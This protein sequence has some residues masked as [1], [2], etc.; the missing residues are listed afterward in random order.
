MDWGNYFISRSEINLSL[1]STNS[2]GLIVLSFVIS[3]T[4]STFCFY[5]V[6]VA[7]NTADPNARK[8]A[9]VS[10]ALTL[11]CSVWSMHF[12]GLLALRICAPVTYNMAITLISV[13][14]SMLAS[15]L[16][17]NLFIHPR[18]GQLRLM[19]SGALVGAGIG[20]MHY[21]GMQAMVM[22]PYIRYQPSWFSLSIVVAI[23][24]STF[25][26]WLANSDFTRELKAWKRII[27][28]GTVLGCAVCFMH[29]LGMEAAVFVGKPIT[30]APVAPDG[31]TALATAIT[32]GML[33]ICVNGVGL[34]LIKYREIA[35]AA[36]KES[37]EQ[38]SLIKQLKETQQQLL[39]S[40]KM[41]SIGQLAAGIAHEIN[42][43]IGFVYS[44]VNT[45]ENYVKTLFDVIARYKEFHSHLKLAGEDLSIITA[46]EK[47]SDIAYIEEDIH[48]LLKESMDGLKRVKDIVQSLKEFAHVDIREWAIADIHQGLDTTLNI[49]KNEIKYKATVE[50]HYGNIPQI[51]CIIAQLN[52]VFMNLLVNA[53][54]AIQERGVITISTGMSKK[55]GEDWVWIKVADTGSGIA[56][57][58]L[59]RVFDPFFTTKPV[60][61]GT[62]LGLSLSYGI[63]ESHGGQIK[64]ESELGRGTSFTI[65]LPA[66]G[67]DKIKEM[68]PTS[69]SKKAEESTK[70]PSPP[71]IAEV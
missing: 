8:I 19:V 41:A 62:G 61:N 28:C 66:K 18:V 3:I 51:N 22:A 54:Q 60:G 50:K 33:F 36:Q 6:E 13:L 31:T 21:V 58:H 20:A 49:V 1:I 11:G 32:F 65:L 47:N 39:Q 56:P 15:F 59:N 24:L 48:E 26:L 25:S 29:Y 16:A 7:K 46:I 67:A 34:N 70:A 69:G 68:A 35:Q 10:G 40:E 37:E 9:I 17:F 27:L 64:V 53:A 42:N 71:E 63:I 12:I 2:I 52:Q 14:P 23:A 43:P 38:Q 30:P 4:C 5:I 44:N 45:L 57:E 55:E